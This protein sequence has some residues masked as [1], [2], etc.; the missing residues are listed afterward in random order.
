MGALIGLMGNQAHAGSITLTFD[1]NGTVIYSVVSNSP[2]QFVNADLNVLNPLLTQKGSAY[3]FSALG[4]TSNFTGTNCTFLTTTGTVNM[5]GATGTTTAVLSV[6][7]TQSGFLTPIGS[8]DAIESTNGT[9]ADT[10]GTTTFTGD[11]DTTSLPTLTFPFAT[12][13]PQAHSRTQE[14]R[15]CPT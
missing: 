11:V 2:N 3:Q 9:Y 14:L 15:S 8:S 12:P 7:T 5:L 6:D 13:P 4:A 1:L 10:I